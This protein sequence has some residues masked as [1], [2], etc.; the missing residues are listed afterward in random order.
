MVLNPGMDHSLLSKARDERRSVD[1]IFLHSAPFAERTFKDRCAS[2]RIVPVCSTVHYGLLS[3]IWFIMVIMVYYGYNGLSWLLCN[4]GLSWLLWFIMVIMVYC[5]FFG[6]WIY[7]ITYSCTHV[8]IHSIL[9]IPVFC[10]FRVTSYIT[11]GDGY[12]PIEVG[13]NIIYNVSWCNQPIEVC[14]TS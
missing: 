2:A 4:Y 9:C 8:P 10:L 14:A 7:L 3:L 13:Y 12:Q 11:L 1:I 6:L 5:A